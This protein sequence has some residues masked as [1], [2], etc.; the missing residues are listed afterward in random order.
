MPMYAYVNIF[1]I[2]QLSITLHDLKMMKVD[3]N[4]VL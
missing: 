1:I 3:L 4:Q 2:D